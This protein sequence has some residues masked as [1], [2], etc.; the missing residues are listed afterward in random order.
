MHLPQCDEAVVPK[1][2]RHVAVVCYRIRSIEEGDTDRAAREES[3]GIAE[4]AC[5]V[6]RSRLCYH[7]EPMPAILDEIIGHDRE[8]ASLLADIARGN[9]AHCYLFTGPPHLGKYSIARW[10]AYRLLI[11]GVPPHEHQTVRE[12]VERL[13]HP[14][15]IE[16]DQLWIA[17]TCDDWSVIARSSN[18]PQMHRSKAKSP[19]RTDTIGIDDIRAIAERLQQTG[20]T[21]RRFCIIRSIDRLHTAAANA[22]LKTLEEPP[23]DVTF[24]LTASHTATLL[25]TVVSRARV[26]RFSPVA[27]PTLANAFAS[28]PADDRA[29][30]LLVARGAPGLVHRLLRDPE[31]LRRHR[32]LHADATRFWTSLSPLQRQRWLLPFAERGQPIDD[33]LLHASIALRALDDPVRLARG[34]AA[35]EVLARDLT[36]N[37]TR[38]LL[39]QRFAL[40]A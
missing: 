30:A 27:N 18:A 19:P 4:H 9:V 2:S 23:P 28:A 17:D 22:F 24:L 7:S 11:D 5:S 16:L 20:V 26:L 13:I 3:E 21:R 38:A 35:L 14:D 15:V 37:A 36:S 6:P 1:D 12:Q 34:V 25:P 8:R 32:Q 31:E 10:F 29:L 39:L 40:A 33:L